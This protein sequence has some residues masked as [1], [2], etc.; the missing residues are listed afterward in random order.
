MANSLQKSDLLAKQCEQL[1]EI[2]S[3]FNKTIEDTIATATNDMNRLLTSI[4][5]TIEETVSMATNDLNEWEQLKVNLS[6]TRLSGKVSLD[7]GGRVFA[8]TVE[9]LTSEE[10]TFFTALLSR[11]WDLEKDEKG[12]IFIDRNGDLFAEI[13]DF[14]RNPSE[15]ILPEE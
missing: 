2:V 6:K 11:Q 3:K 4:K 14:M 9:T 8:T 10:D 13:L 15:F 1:S 5:Q 12:R 7:V